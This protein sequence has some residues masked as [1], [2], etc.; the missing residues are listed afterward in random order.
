MRKLLLSLLPGL[1][2]LVTGCPH[3]VYEI[4]LVPQGQAVKRQL[5]FYAEDGTD[6]QGLAVYKNFGTQ[7]LARITRLYPAGAVSSNGFRHTATSEFTGALPSDVGGAGTYSQVTTTL[8]T[9]GFYVERFRGDDDLADGMAKR[10]RAADETVDLIIGWSR[11]ELGRERGYRDLRRF[12]DGNFRNDL[13]NMGL[14]A[15]QAR[16]SV[17]WGATTPDE[18]IVRYAQYL[19]ERGYWKVADLPELFRAGTAENARPYLVRIQRLLASKLGVPNTAAIPRSLAFLG[20]PGQAASSMAK[21]LRTTEQY[22]VRLRH[23]EKERV[24]EELGSVKQRLRSLYGTNGPPPARAKSQAPDPADIMGELLGELLELDLPGSG[25]RLTVRL[26][27]PSA[28]ARTNGKWDAARHR[29]VWD[30]MLDNAETPGRIPVLCYANWSQ[31]DEAVQRRHFGRV[32][33]RG[34]ELSQYCLWRAALDE[35]QSV[36]WEAFLTGL[37]PGPGLAGQIH[38]FQFARPPLATP[39]NAPNAG[40]DPSDFPQTLLEAAL[41]AVEKGQGG[42]PRP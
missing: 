9:A 21:Y 33:L 37:E 25:D 26:S 32:L 7:E 6:A 5:I 15:W 36:E 41:E 12:L 39:P 14:Y 34:D 31:P 13:K 4:D 35:K 17:S 2:L 28:P 20:D 22:R 8:G 38:R 3:N 42:K 10:L 18:F 1:T 40:T 29:V 30:S 23:W 24:T 11:M 19:A 16:N 27:L